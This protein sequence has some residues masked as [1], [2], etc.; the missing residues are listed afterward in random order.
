MN[1]MGFSQELLHSLDPIRKFPDYLKK[2]ANPK[3]DIIRAWQGEIFTRKIQEGEEHKY[4]LSIALAKFAFKPHVQPLLGGKFFPGVIYPAVS[5]N[6]TGDNIA[7]LPSIVD[8]AIALREVLFAKV[9]G[10]ADNVDLRDP[11]DMV[12]NLDFFDRSLD[13][14]CGGWLIWGADKSSLEEHLTRLGQRRQAAFTEIQH[15]PSHKTES[16]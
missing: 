10:I 12:V 5:I 15:I 13:H 16:E 6:L 2:S 3:S 1:H 11:M 7:I 9:T 4:N 8:Q 14:S